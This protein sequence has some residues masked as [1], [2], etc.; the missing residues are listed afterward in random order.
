ML[1]R[2]VFRVQRLGAGPCGVAAATFWASGPG[3]WRSRSCSSP[4]FWSSKALAAEAALLV[5]LQA[6]EALGE[7]GVQPGVDGVGVARAEDARACDGVWGG[8]VG[9]PQQG[10]GAFTDEGLGMMG[11]V[12]EQLLP[13]LV[14]K[15]E[16]T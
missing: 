1:T 6:V 16:S 5:A 11:A 8:A 14:G 4:F 10:G 9:D 2:M 15:V 13:L 3:P 12:F 7:E